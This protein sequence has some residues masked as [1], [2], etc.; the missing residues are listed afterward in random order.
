MIQLPKMRN[1]YRMSLPRRKFREMVLQ[2]LFAMNAEDQEEVEMI[3]FFMKQLKVSKKSAQEALLY[4]KEIQSHLAEIDP[5][6]EEASHSYR[7]ERIGQVE[8][9]IIRLGVYEFLYEK[10]ISIQ[11]A[12]S[13][14]IR[15]CRKFATPEGAD[16]VNAVLDHVCKKEP[17]NIP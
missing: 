10:D 12:I 6:I 5:K 2:I 9:N 4:A 11:V 3:S 13:E 8:K 14:A 17:P 1:N 16:F 7:M 15:L